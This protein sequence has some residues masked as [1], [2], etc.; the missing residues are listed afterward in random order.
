MYNVYE[1]SMQ[2]MKSYGFSTRRQQF[3]SSITKDSLINGGSIRLLIE[4]LTL[5]AGYDGNE[6]LKQKR[7]PL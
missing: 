4:I 6:I 5:I 2:T 1:K 3:Q 7:H